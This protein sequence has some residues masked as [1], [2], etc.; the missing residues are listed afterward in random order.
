MTSQRAV[1]RATLLG[2]GAL[3]LWSTLALLT[4]TA[5]EVPPFALTALSFVA[6]AL[7]WAAYSVL[8][9]RLAEIPSDAVGG[10]CAVTAVLALLCH[11]ALEPSGWPSGAV[12]WTVLALGLGPVG[13]A[14]FLWDVGVKH[15]N[16]RVL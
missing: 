8:S 10:F 12:W 9:R 6:A 2:I 3:C 14:F 13:A 11:L 1:A 4:R 5:Y 15:G 16:I 7:V